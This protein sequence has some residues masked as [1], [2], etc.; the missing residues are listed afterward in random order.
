MLFFIFACGFFIYY[1]IIKTITVQ[2][3]NKVV[4]CKCIHNYL[5]TH[6][7][8]SKYKISKLKNIVKHIFFVYINK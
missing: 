8:Y 2:R 3:T 5:F 7:L 6:I 4:Y 1:K